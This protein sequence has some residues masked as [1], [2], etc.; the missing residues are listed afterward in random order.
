MSRESILKIRETE[1]KAEQI[2]EAA[3]AQ[4]RAAVEA[5]EENGRVLCTR[6]EKEVAAENARL[7]EELRERTA[8]TVANAAEDARKEADT[9]KKDAFL[10][11]RGAEKIVIR[12]LMSK[13]R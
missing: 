12:G 11:K 9:M 8:Q 4:A 3:R 13:C 6:T 10:N 1:Q 2:V 5:A 7:M